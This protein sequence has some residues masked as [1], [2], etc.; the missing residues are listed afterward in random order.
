MAVDRRAVIAGA[1]A[2]LA[3]PSLAQQGADQFEIGADILREGAALPMSFRRGARNGDV[4]MVEF[5]DYNCPYCRAAARDMGAL[6][7]AEPNLRLLLVNY[8]VLGEGSVMAAKV[9]CAVATETPEKF[10]AFHA[11]LMAS[12]GV[13]GAEEALR[14]AAGQ[15]VESDI[16]LETANS[17]VTAAALRAAADFGQRN[18]LG[19]TPAWLVG[20]RAHARAFV[21]GLSLA[22]RRAA[23]AAAR[24]V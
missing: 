10:P 22:Q 21:G 9:G 7:Q 24:G 12:R 17:D 6:L 15:G 19:A 20:R 5:F 14:I 16:V 3:S 4:T 13:V 2:S 1:A 18:R 8:A 11:E 23:V